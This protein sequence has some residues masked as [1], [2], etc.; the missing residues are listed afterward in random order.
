MVQAQPMTDA[1][2]RKA[3]VSKASIGEILR[4][5]VMARA[6]ILCTKMIWLATLI[7][8]FAMGLS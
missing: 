4:P 3:Q 7:E 1:R 2:R 8:L 6:P 5:P